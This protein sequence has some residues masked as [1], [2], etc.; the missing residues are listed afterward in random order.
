MLIVI[1][2]HSV[3][4]TDQGTLHIVPCHICSV[5]LHLN[6]SGMHLSMLQFMH[7]DYLCANIHHC[8]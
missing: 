6:F 4:R 3:I 5:E 7:K 1:N 8:L 2:S